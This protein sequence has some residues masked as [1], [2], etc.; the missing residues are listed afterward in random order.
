M[1]SNSEVQWIRPLTKCLYVCKSSVRIPLGFI[2]F[3]FPKILKTY[4]YCLFIFYL[5]FSMPNIVNL[6]RLNSKKYF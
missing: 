6:K 5:F 2:I 4:F 3:T 1:L